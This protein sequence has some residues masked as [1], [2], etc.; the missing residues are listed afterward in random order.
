M[1]MTRARAAIL[2][3]NLSANSEEIAKVTVI[4]DEIVNSIVEKMLEYSTPHIGD[5]HINLREE[6]SLELAK[7]ISFISEKVVEDRLKGRSIEEIN[8]EL[9][10]QQCFD[11]DGQEKINNTAKN[12]AD[13]I[14]IRKYK[15]RWE[16]KTKAALEKEKNPTHNKLSPKPVD[17][18]HYIPI[19]FI[20][21]YW[22][23]KQS[24]F[25]NIKKPDGEIEKKKVSVGQWG[26]SKNLYS[27]RLEAYFGLLE[28]DAVRPIEMLLNVEPLNRPQREALVGFIVIQ[29]LR[30]PHFMEN[31]KSQMIPV[32]ASEVGGGRE[33][34]DEYRRSVYE[35]L[36]S[37]NEFYDKI[38][39]PV[40]FNRWAI[41]RS[42]N[43]V[44]VLPDACNIFGKYDESQYVVMPLTPTDCL[45][46]LP[47]SNV[48]IR[49]VPHYIK[50]SS[51]LARDISNIL[52]VS[53]N[54]EFLSASSRQFNSQIDEEPNKIIQ[55]IILSIA[56]ITADK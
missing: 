56:K 7:L 28:G 31:L 53:A 30:N 51:F 4:W 33:N 40:L 42:E 54:K 34:D 5:I 41:V 26:F 10:R 46:V 43:P 8:E 1:G 47:Y 13:R 2:K 24:V 35:S 9:E 12:C 23:E 38:A 52:V 45:V 49:I 14:W 25:R 3:Q 18:N 17:K 55:R 6:M 20:R 48:N 29:R 27:D 36:Y 21:R 39:K 16:P 50:A 37:Q 15:E 32:V 22:S 19:S 11:K 44:F